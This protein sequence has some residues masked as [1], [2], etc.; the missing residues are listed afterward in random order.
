MV[1]IVGVAVIVLGAIMAIYFA[2]LQFSAPQFPGGFTH[3]F[4][5]SG[6]G[7]GNYSY[8]QTRF[9]STRLGGAVF[10]G[11]SGQNPYRIVI[12]ILVLL[13]GIATY[14]YSELKLTLIKN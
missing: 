1:R 14:K 10:T 4:N 8:N 3:R 7:N 9:N 13:L 6:A 11:Q 2:Y 12:G 5:A